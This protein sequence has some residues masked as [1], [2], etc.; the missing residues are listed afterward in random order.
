MSQDRLDARLRAIKLWGLAFICLTV[1]AWLALG[2]WRH[3]IGGLFIGELGGAYVVV[4]LIGQGHRRDNMQG[5]ALFASGMVGMFTRILALVAV[6]VV[7]EHWRIYFNP[8]SAL[9]GYLLGFVFIF[10]GL[11]GLASN[12][13]TDS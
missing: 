10:V 5:T 3:A 11:Y 6:M 1:I 4:S 9:I 12:R 13:S 8:Y 7:A 2:M